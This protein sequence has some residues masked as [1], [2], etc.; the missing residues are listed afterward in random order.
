MQPPALPSSR[1]AWPDRD[2][3]CFSEGVELEIGKVMVRWNVFFPEEH[4]AV[5]SKALHEVLRSLQDK[6]PTQMRKAY[7][8]RGR[9]IVQWRYLEDAADPVPRR[10]ENFQSENHGERDS[11]RMVSLKSPLSRRR[12]AWIAHFS[13]EADSPSASDRCTPGPHAGT[14]PGPDAA[15]RLTQQVQVAEQ[16]HPGPRIRDGGRA[17]RGVRLPELASRRSI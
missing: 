14:A 7:Q 17:T 15:Q 4:P 10:P 12:S 6:I 16:F 11:F 1:D 3:I 8:W 9:L 5:V 2:N 13:C